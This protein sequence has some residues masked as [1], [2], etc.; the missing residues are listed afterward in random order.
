MGTDLRGILPLLETCVPASA[1]EL[2]MEV[3][4]MKQALEM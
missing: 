3:W 1:L 4:K 2:N